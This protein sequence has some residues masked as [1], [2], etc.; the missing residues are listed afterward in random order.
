MQ[1]AC[2]RIVMVDVKIYQVWSIPLTSSSLFLSF[3]SAIL[4]LLTALSSLFQKTH[5]FGRAKSFKWHADW[6]FWRVEI[7]MVNVTFQSHCQ[8]SS[9]LVKLS[10]LLHISYHLLSPES[11]TLIL[12]WA[13]SCT[14]TFAIER[15]QMHWLPWSSLWVNSRKISP[16]GE[17]GPLRLLEESDP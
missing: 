10:H 6:C 1:E 12:L 2:S 17:S 3:S 13:M 9:Y 5:V 7:N 4:L 8:R 15:A 14:L 11:V 16:A